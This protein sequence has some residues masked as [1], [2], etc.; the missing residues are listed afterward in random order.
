MNNSLTIALLIIVLIVLVLFILIRNR[1]DRKEFE[2][3]LN[4]DY[5]KPKTDEVDTEGKDTV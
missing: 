1:K 5:K 3:Q 2:E 4:Q